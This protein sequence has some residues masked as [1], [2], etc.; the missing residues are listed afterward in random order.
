MLQELFE[1]Q[2]TPYNEEDTEW[3]AFVSAHPHGSLLQMTGWARLKS[4]FGWSPRRVWLRRDGRL[5]AGA[6]LLVRAAAMGLMRVAY[7]PHGPLVD[8]QDDEMV[9]VLLNQ[10][11][12][13]AYEHGAGLLKMEP[14][15][16]QD[17][18]PPV[19]WETLCARHG[20]LANS[21]TIQ[22]PRTIVVDL[23]APEEEIL[24]RM[25]QKTRYNIRLAEKR[26]VTVRLGTAADLPLFI[27]LLRITGARDDF[28]VH[29]SDYYRAAY[30]L[31]APE[32]AALLIAEHEEKALAALMVFAAG[33]RAAYL[34]GA[35]ANEGREL[36][37][38]YAVQWAAMR[39]AREQGCTE[40][41]LW[42]IPDEPENALE[43]AFGERSDGLWGVYRFKRGFGGQVKRTVGTADRVYN[44]LVYR[45]YK[46]RRG[47]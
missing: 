35:S 43:A 41:D 47:R 26:G 1:L 4:R 31:F 28:S 15:L 32:H 6:Q 12:F 16:W 34:Y 33:Q 20:C 40:Y 18:M 9:S 13:A 2:E 23:Q 22:P 42:G 7:I 24:A 27:R 19:Q 14:L 21:D 8:W 44:K 38:S 10:I 39:W 5:V 46:W 17:E 37:P 36:M 29:A 3:D 11:D 45:L 30:E 25:K